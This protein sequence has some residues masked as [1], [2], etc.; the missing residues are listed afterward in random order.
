MNRPRDG[1]QLAKRC[2]NAT[3]SGL[4]HPDGTAYVGE[5]ALN[6]KAD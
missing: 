6:G 2:E 4:L 1:V 3:H 5:Q